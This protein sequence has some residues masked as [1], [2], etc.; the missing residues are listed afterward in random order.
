MGMM[1]HRNKKKRAEKESALLK[2][3]ENPKQYTKE[4][5][6]EL[7]YTRTNIN[8]MSKEDLVSLGKNVGIENAEEK[9]GADLKKELIEK[10]GL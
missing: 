5:P 7:Q 6:E 4:V 9:N 1:I 10:F 2:S 3:A 8:R